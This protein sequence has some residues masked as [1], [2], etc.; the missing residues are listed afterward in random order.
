MNS[1]IPKGSIL[2]C[3]NQ[4]I[5]DGSGYAC[6]RDLWGTPN[7]DRLSIRKTSWA[8]CRQPSDRPIQWSYLANPYKSNLLN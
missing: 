8:V 7:G 6:L 3:E 2:L 1:V 4:S 5:G